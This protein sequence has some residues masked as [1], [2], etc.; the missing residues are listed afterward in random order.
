MMDVATTTGETAVWEH[1]DP[2]GDVIRL[3]KP[4]RIKGR[5]PRA[6]HRVDFLD[7][8]RGAHSLHGDS[9]AAELGRI[10]NDVGAE[11]QGTPDVLLSRLLELFGE[12][13]RL[14]GQPAAAGPLEVMPAPTLAGGEVDHRAFSAGW[15]D[16]NVKL[17]CEDFADAAGKS[18]AWAIAHARHVHEI[19]SFMLKASTLYVASRISINASIAL[20]ETITDLCVGGP[21]R[22]FLAA[23]QARAQTLNEGADLVLRRHAMD[24]AESV[25]RAAIACG[26]V[27]ALP[28]AAQHASTAEAYASAAEALIAS[29]GGFL[30]E[31]GPF[32]G[33]LRS[34][35]SAYE[36]LWVFDDNGESVVDLKFLDSLCLTAPISLTLLVNERSVSDNI[37]ADLVHEWIQRT[38]CVALEEGLRSGR[39]KL[40][41]ENDGCPSFEPARLSR[42]GRDAVKRATACVCRG[43]ALFETFQLI[44]K[45]TYFGFVTSSPFSVDKTGQARGTPVLIHGEPGRTAWSPMGE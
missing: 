42:A 16:T 28:D 36:L 35:G 41:A 40:I 7:V 6:D 5:L 27:L 24:D 21:P 38:D 13:S 45:D 20:Q 26:G 32:V 1:R 22:A 30:G 44:R 31:I 29:R 23:R 17:R 10:A 33:E 14:V 9:I 43:V 39:V 2:F 8:Y 4:V 37:P 18:E 11:L 34:A 15:I 12:T 19:Y 25:L 3:A